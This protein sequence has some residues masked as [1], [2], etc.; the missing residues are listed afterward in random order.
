MKKKE[1]SKVT[2]AKPAKNKADLLFSYPP[3]SETK[4]QQNIPS[5]KVQKQKH[6]YIKERIWLFLPRAF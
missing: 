6:H 5:V 3:K 2:T 1:L 4:N